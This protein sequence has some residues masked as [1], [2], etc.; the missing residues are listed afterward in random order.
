MSTAT[1]PEQSTETGRHP[2][3][4]P[5]ISSQAFVGETDRMALENLKKVPTAPDGASQ[6]PRA[7]L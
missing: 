3:L 1:S 5:H 4:F 6:V 2:V 7:C